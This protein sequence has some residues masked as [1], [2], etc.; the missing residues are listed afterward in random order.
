[1]SS[2]VTHLLVVVPVVVPS[3][4]DDL[5]VRQSVKRLV[6]CKGQHLPQGHSEAPDV[7]LGGELALRR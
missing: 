7:R 4:L 3:V 5:L 1:M 2:G 6:T